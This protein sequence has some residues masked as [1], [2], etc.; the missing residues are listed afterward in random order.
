M[1]VNDSQYNVGMPTK[2]SKT[3]QALAR[4]AAGE[5]VAIA[6]RALGISTTAV[7]A[8]MRRREGK[9]ICPC[10]G[11]V[12]RDGFSTKKKAKR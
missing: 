7:Y 10:C 12:V 6:S 1:N 3:M 9:T 11:Q 5:T 2:P 4:I 8:A